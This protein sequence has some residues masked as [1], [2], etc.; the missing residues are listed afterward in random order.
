M[1]EAVYRAAAEQ[2]LQ[3]LWQKNIARHPNDSRRQRR[4]DEYMRYNREG[5][6]VTFT[7]VMG[8]RKRRGRARC[9]LT[10]HAAR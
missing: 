9:R 5:L 6:A 4:R 7:V 2:D 8:G 1:S 3:Q 10:P